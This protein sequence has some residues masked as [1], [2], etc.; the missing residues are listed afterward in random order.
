[1]SKIYT[2]CLKESQQ[3]VILRE[4]LSRTLTLI[5]TL[6]GRLTTSINLTWTPKEWMGTLLTSLGYK[7]RVN[8]TFT[9]IIA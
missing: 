7:V 2:E 8:L 4:S 5:N 3:P 9:Y 1:M 6:V